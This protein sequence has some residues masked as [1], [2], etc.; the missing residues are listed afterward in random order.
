MTDIIT[1]AG[2]KR[3]SLHA[4]R[5]LECE[6]ARCAAGHAEGSAQRRRVLADLALI[7]R[8]IAVRLRRGPRPGL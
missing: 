1:I 7:R 8:E 2:L 5:S 4:L 3:L 6:L